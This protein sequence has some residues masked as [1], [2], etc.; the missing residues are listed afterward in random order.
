MSWWG[1]LLGGGFGFMLGGP[2]GALF[3]AALGHQLDKGVNINFDERQ[4]ASADT[5]NELAQ[6]AFFTA[7]F[8]MLGYLAKADGR[9]SKEE[10]AY[11]ERVMQNMSLSSEQR[12]AAIWL[13]NEGKK[14]SF[15]PDEILL[16]LKQQLGRRRN[17]MRVFIE[18]QVQA[19]FED[20]VLHTA[21][22]QVLLN[23]CRM[24]GI[25][26]MDYRAIVY[27]GRKQSKTAGSL[28]LAD[29][30]KILGVEKSA[31]DSEVKKA[32]R[33]L[34]SQ[35]HPDKLVSKGLPEEMMRIATEKT[36]QI[37]KAYELVKDNRSSLR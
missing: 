34:L 3:G 28:Q 26:E 23:S 14:P 16:Q 4:G 10:I 21:E 1:K 31:T 17:L 24:L 11:A 33:R 15:H 35:H 18:I 30:Y 32:Y 22:E 5:S 37:K 2:L 13:F 20:G 7:T 25:S 29:A 8:S 6:T 19:A 27:Q 12:Q 36:H 9:V